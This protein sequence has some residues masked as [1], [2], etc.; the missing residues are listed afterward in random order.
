MLLLRANINESKH[1]YNAL[2]FRGI[3]M[4]FHAKR[5]APS[6]CKYQ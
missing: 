4:F 2:H 5:H 6:A 3:S 1:G